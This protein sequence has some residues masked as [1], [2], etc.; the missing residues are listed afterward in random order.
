MGRLDR[1]QA[2]SRL[3]RFYEAR[4]Y[5]TVGLHEFPQPT[6]PPVSRLEKRLGGSFPIASQSGRL[7]RRGR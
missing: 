6:W 7:A 2:N 3:I 4:G 1:I 5:R